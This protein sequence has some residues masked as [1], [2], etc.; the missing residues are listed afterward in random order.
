MPKK[1]PGALT[2]PLKQNLRRLW[3]RQSTLFRVTIL[4]SVEP[5]PPPL[6]SG[7]DQDLPLWG[8][9]CLV[10]CLPPCYWP[11]RMQS[12]MAQ[13]SAKLEAST[14]FTLGALLGWGGSGR[15]GGWRCPSWRCAIGWGGGRGEGWGGEVFNV[16]GGGRG[17]RRD[18][19]S[20]VEGGG[21]QES[22]GR[23]RSPPPPPRKA[24][25]TTRPA[26]RALLPVPLLR[27]PRLCL[28]LSKLPNGYYSSSKCTRQPPRLLPY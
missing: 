26:P 8:R 12:A 17:R 1:M 5:P 23:K 16:K 21:S 13:R 18:Q 27:L 10:L 11:I 14:I 15:T 22:R 2:L 25:L 19:V 3:R 6:G 24:V 7:P 28:L 4:G 9:A 20:G